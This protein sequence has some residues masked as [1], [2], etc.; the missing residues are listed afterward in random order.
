M[1]SDSYFFI[2]LFVSLVP[3]IFLGFKEKSIRLYRDILTIYFVCFAFRN[4]TH[5][6]LFFLIYILIS[7]CTI[8][9]LIYF[10]SKNKKNK[11]VC[12]IC[13][14]IVL[15][16]LIISKFGRYLAMPGFGFLG[17]SYICFRVIQVILEVYDGL[18]TDIKT[19]NF[20]EFLAF[21]PSLS[22]G[23]ID[24]SRRF[25][26]DNTKIWSKSEYAGLLS[27]GMI[28]IVI[29]IF[30]KYVCSSICF[31]F[32][33]DLRTQIKAIGV[34]SLVTIEYTYAY[35]LY[36][37]FDFA[38]YSLMVI[39]TAYILGIRLPDNFNK[40]FLSIDIKEFW[41]RWHISLSHWF[42]D[43]VFTRFLM[44][45][46]KNKRFKNRTF[47]AVN[48]YILNMLIMG[49]WHGEGKQYLVY[50]LYH[51]ILLAGNELLQ[52]TKIYRKYNKNIIYK[53]VSWF[54]TLN[55]VM[56][57]FLIFSGDLNSWFAYIMN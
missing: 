37:F 54:M 52:K 7:L 9:F 29:G 33:S 31:S 18:I 12:E 53:I 41:N 45:A 50:G 10:Q 14:G 5:Q 57:G 28:K 4:D 11:L 26:N 24:R 55:L 47:A 20:V 40:P 39:G 23:P 15:T 49:I 44:D 30:Y 8:R 19:L 21:F 35:G 32:L 34:I 17:L 25:E 38:G 51:G 27:D 43:F 1:Y 48:G 13:I 42:R 22:A 3:A 2:T 36:L 16:P 56:F 46:L 6:L